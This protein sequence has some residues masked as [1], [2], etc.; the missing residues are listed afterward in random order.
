M[1]YRVYLAARYG[2]RDELNGYR[3]RL[4][5][6][7]FE[8]TSH[9]LTADPPAPIA[10]LTE[11]HWR[12]LA[13]TDVDDIRRADALV[14]FA[15]EAEGGGGGRHVELGAR[16]RSTSSSSWWGDRS[17]SFTGSRRSR[18]LWTGT[19]RTRRSARRRPGRAERRPAC[20][21][22]R[23]CYPRRSEDACL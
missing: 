4:H 17:T 16:S 12:D 1:P 21:R 14:A 15:E 9:W 7:G 2:R 3:Q 13:E 20:P 5:G 6:D 10:E 18:S 23:R 22:G 11:A 19:A 8:V